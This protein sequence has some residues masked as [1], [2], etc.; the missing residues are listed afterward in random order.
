MRNKEKK[1]DDRIAFVS[2]R[3]KFWMGLDFMLNDQPEKI[4]KFN[5]KFKIKTKVRNL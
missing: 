1:R 5:Q 2:E 4:G 3:V